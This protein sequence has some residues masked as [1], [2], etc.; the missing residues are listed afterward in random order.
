MAEYSKIPV[1]ATLK[2]SLFKVA[3]V[4]EQ[5]TELRAS[6]R[7]SRL[8]PL[9]YESSQEDHKYGISRKWLEDAKNEWLNI[10]DWR[11]HETHINSFPNFTTNIIDDDQKEYTIH[12]VA[13]FSENPKAVPLM[14]FHGWPGSFLEFLPI[15]SVLQKKYTPET[16]PYHVI[17]PSNIGYAFSSKPPLDKDFTV[18]DVARLF[19]KLA[20][21][22]SF[23]SGYV[24]QG[25]DIGSAVARMMALTYDGCKVNFSPIT[26]P[27]EGLENVAL[28]D[29]E[30]CGIDIT[31][32]FVTTGSAYAFEQGSRPSTIGLVLNSSPLALLAW[33]GEKFIDWSDTTPPVDEIL[34]HIT[35]YWLT[36]T[37]PTSIFPYRE[38]FNRPKSLVENS[39]EMYIKKPFG[40]SAFPREIIQPPKDWV[41]TTGNLV[42]FRR[43]E[44][45]GHFA[46]FERPYELLAD[47]EEFIKQVWT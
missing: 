36:N 17:A 25:G 41:A 8:G 31:T 10:F 44:T 22:L 12:F 45:G 29:V 15:L 23:G 38:R 27:P 20:E 3:I 5:L 11:K 4:E 46:A 24:V 14:L 1:A 7:Y 28:S 16:L 33:I 19:H 2:P 32:K 43:H 40:F 35:L 30:K 26:S 47:V 6:L 13:L 18:R 9:T 39:D 37:Y 42:F 34:A 21:S